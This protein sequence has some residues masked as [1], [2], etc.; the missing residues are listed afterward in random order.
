MP[1]KLFPAYPDG[2]WCEEWWAEHG[3][4]PEVRDAR[5]YYRWTTD[6][7]RPIE[8]AWSFA[9]PFARRIGE[10][11]DGLVIVR[12]APPDLNPNV[13]Y[14]MY[15]E[16]RPDNSVQVDE[17]R[18][19]HYHGDD[20]DGWKA[21]R[22]PAKPEAVELARLLDNLPPGGKRMP[23]ALAF[24]AEQMRKNGH[25]D[26]RHGGENDQTVHSHI[27][28]PVKYVFPPGDGIAKRIDIHPLAVELFDTADTVYFPIEGCIKA[29]AILT[30]ILSTGERAAVLSA[31]SVTLWNAKELRWIADHYL[32]GKLVVI[33]PDADGIENDLVT[34]QATFLRT[35]LRKWGVEAEIRL[36]TPPVDGFPE[37]YRAR[38]RKDKTYKYE[39]NGVDD[40]LG[41]DGSL[42]DLVPYDREAP[43]W[44]ADAYGKVAEGLSLHAPQDGLYRH[45]LSTL[46]TVMDISPKTV[47]REVRRLERLGAIKVYGDLSTRYAYKEF[48]L[49][50]ED[51]P[52]IELHPD[53][54]TITLPPPKGYL[55]EGADR[56]AED[57][58]LKGVAHIIVGRR[59]WEAAARE[60]AMQKLAL[61]KRLRRLFVERL[62][63]AEYA[64]PNRLPNRA[65]ARKWGLTRYE[66]DKIVND[67]KGEQMNQAQFNEVAA[68]VRKTKAEVQR[69]GEFFPTPTQEAEGYASDPVKDGEKESRA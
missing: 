29:D 2:S 52:I 67:L 43:P 38:V 62:V 34:S 10:Q 56:Q 7:T 1:P 17:R 11:S 53:L 21:F 48:G 33:V 39:R 37:D 57:R 50:W 32:R 68:D 59:T 5:G 66:V 31:P 61:D 64:Q 55:G 13:A 4:S 26:K 16:V 23:R 6:D 46:A 24:D 30:A 65:I 44:V 22:F 3:I 20:P 40:H 41:N 63:C 47:E 69:I 42:D 15:A 19:W 27:D 18:K 12:H 25:T 49:E 8:L 51:G 28:E 36:P 14:P 45:S 54:R 60:R 9:R 35:Y 58:A